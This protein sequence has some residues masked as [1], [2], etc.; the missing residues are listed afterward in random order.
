MTERKTITLYETHL[1]E[2]QAA[3]AGVAS[4]DFLVQTGSRLVFTLQVLSVS[5]PGVTVQARLKNGYSVEVPFLQV[6]TL[7]VVNAGFERKV[8][9]DFHNRFEYE[10][11]VTGG[12]ADVALAMTVHDNALETRV[13]IENAEIDVNLTHYLNAN[14]R[15]DSVRLGDG[16]HEAAVNPDGSLNV[17]IVN[18]SADPELPRNVYD[19]KPSVAQ[20]SDQ[21]IVIYIVP[22]GKRALLQRVEYSGEQIARY[23]VKIAGATQA[24]RRTHHGSGLTGEFV[25]H[26]ASDEGLPVAGGTAIEL[27]V[28][29]DRPGTGSFEGRI[30]ALEIG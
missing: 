29:H 13:D 3:L 11:E 5:A 21:R 1:L 30:M 14:G 22:T 8:L 16:D 18:S 20:G 19:E 12:T 10:V 25:F 23:W 26:G 9:T 2:R 27:F 6:L 17:N 15:Y 24:S 4:G 28:R 7:G